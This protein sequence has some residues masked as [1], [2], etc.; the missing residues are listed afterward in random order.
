VFASA[1]FETTPDQVV[2][3]GEL[4]ASLGLGISKD[5]LDMVMR[6][7]VPSPSPITI[8]MAESEPGQ[9]NYIRF[10]YLCLG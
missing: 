8:V 3:M 1:G 2:N 5:P 10:V 6:V 7:F 9:S 4:Q